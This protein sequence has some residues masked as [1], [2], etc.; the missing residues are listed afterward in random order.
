M[1]RMQR[2]HGKNHR[3]KRGRSRNGYFVEF[4]EIVA[5]LE[6]YHIGKRK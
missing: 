6:T 3:E 1:K 4:G 2:T 5:I